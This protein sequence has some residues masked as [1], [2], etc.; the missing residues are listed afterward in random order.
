MSEAAANPQNPFSTGPPEERPQAPP[1]AEKSPYMP[2]GDEKTEILQPRREP[3]PSTPEPVPWAPADTT[4]SPTSPTALLQAEIKSKSHQVDRL[5]ETVEELQIQLDAMRKDFSSQNADGQLELRTLQSLLE[6]S[7]EQVEKLQGDALQQQKS[8]RTLKSQNLRLQHQLNVWGIPV[9]ASGAE[10]SAP[11]SSGEGGRLFFPELSA[12]VEGLDPVPVVLRGDIYTFGFP[13]LLHFLA[14]SNLT[15]VLTMVSDGV[16]SKLYLE[17]GILRLT[18]WNHRSEELCL[19][20]LLRQSD[21]VDADI[22]DQFAD[23][24]LYDLEL[25]I[26]ILKREELPT[27]L[28]QSGLREHARVILTFLYET[29]QGAF[30][31]QPGILRRQRYL[32]FHLPILDLLL[33]TAAEVDEKS[34]ALH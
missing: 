3:S 19:A 18:G 30:F 13:N 16:V 14:N 5:T 9:S 31:F 20:N 25:A 15:G 10:S 23:E 2:I 4:T 1:S 32:Q 12:L 26:S 28:I 11:D 8:K 27:N 29:E 17:K 21:L 7:H 33:V 34:R 22:L 24:P 6:R